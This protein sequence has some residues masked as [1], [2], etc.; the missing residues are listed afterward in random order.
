MKRTDTLRWLIAYTLA[1]LAAAALFASGCA[2]STISNPFR[3]G[4]EDSSASAVNEDRLLETARA[5]S[6]TDLPGGK[7][8][9]C[10]QVV[11]WPRDRLLT[12]YQPGHVGDQAAVVHRGEIT[13]MAREC[14]LYS[15]R[16]I[17]KYGFAGRVLLGPK[18]SPGT[19]TL[20]VN[21]RVA[22]AQQNTLATDK[23]SVTTTIPPAAPAGYFSMVR[24]VAFPITV[25]TRPQDYKVFVAFER[26]VAG[27][28]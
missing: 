2:V 21:V 20:G 10:P 7:S 28:G 4:K 18:G 1:G 27:A 24:E 14:T 12:I 19:V 5:D 17:V 26:N 22:G 23:M 8:A 11:A 16:V 6:G 13:K 15:D 3:S 9:N 25:G